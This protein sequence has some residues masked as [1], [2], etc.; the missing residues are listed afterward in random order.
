MPPGTRFPI[1]NKDGSLSFPAD[2]DFSVQR[3]SDPDRHL[4]QTLVRLAAESI[5]VGR[6]ALSCRY[7]VSPKRR[8][9]IRGAACRRAAG[10]AGR[11]RA[12]CI[13]IDKARLEN[14]LIRQVGQFR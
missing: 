11:T 4:A 8:L 7:T 14:E 13:S 6:T 3:G 12:V 9:T 1:V 10:A 2:G 5:S